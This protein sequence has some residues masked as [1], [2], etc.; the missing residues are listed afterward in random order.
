MSQELIVDRFE[1]KIAIIEYEHG[2]F[3]V[4]R[5]CLPAHAREGDFITIQSRRP[6]KDTQSKENEDR[7]TRL[8]ARD[9]GQDIIDL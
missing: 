7:L 8:K 6:P 3:E 5:S 9:S 4:P 2:H 1:G